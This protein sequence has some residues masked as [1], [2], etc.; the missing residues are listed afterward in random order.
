MPK[1]KVLNPQKILTMKNSILLFA[2]GLILTTTS[3]VKRDRYY[4][5]APK[6]VPYT[7]IDDF[8][9][10]R[11]DWQFADGSNLAYGIISNGTFKIDYNDNLYEA[12]Y[13][14]KSIQL[15]VFNDFTLSTRIGS[16]KNMGLLFGYNGN[17]GAYGYSFTIDYNGYFALYDEGGNGYGADISA[18]VPRTKL[19]FVKINGDWNDIRIE[20]RNKSWIGYI[21]GNRVF[22]VPVQNLKGASVGFVVE[23]NTQGEADY[24][25]ADWFE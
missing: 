5:H 6:L 19:G 12:Y 2:A 13:V 15:N 7:F 21:N 3:C 25:Q 23:A 11:N 17:N 1:S 8:D 16:N 10:N 22:N 20:Q 24:I 14:S 4:N 9:N 18:I